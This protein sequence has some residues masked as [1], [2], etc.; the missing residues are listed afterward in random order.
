MLSLDSPVWSTLEHAYGSA[1]DIPDLLRQLASLPSSE[2][3]NEPWFYI[4]SALAHQGDVYTAS[5]AAVPHVV[6]YLASDPSAASSVY[7]QFPAWI[8]ICRQRHAMTVPSELAADYF[9]ALRRLGNIVGAVI[10]EDW[11]QDFVAFALAALAV[12]KGFALIGE[13]IQ[14]LN[15]TTAESLLR[16]I[17]G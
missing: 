7:F 13:A 8:E 3:T 5:F 6:H 4:W 15:D 16:E 1:V 11:D 10:N 2:G 17:R 12:S 9:E 14:E